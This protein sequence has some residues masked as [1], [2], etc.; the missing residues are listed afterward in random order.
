MRSAWWNSNSS[1]SMSWVS[2]LAMVSF[3]NL[4]DLVVRRLRL[5][6]IIW[7]F[8]KITAFVLMTSTSSSPLL[9]NCVS[10]SSFFS[11]CCITCSPRTDASRF[12]PS[13]L[14]DTSLFTSIAR[15]GFS[16]AAGTALPFIGPRAPSLAVFLRPSRSSDPCASVHFSRR[17]LRS[18]YCSALQ[19]RS[20][21]FFFLPLSWLTESLSPFLPSP[22]AI[23]LLLR[24]PST[25]DGLLLVCGF[26]VS[27]RAR[28]RARWLLLA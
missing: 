5:S 23:G 19:A 15:I 13:L 7:M 9:P 17:W 3:Y 25:R 24:A 27:A 26:L 11:A 16:P 18:G 22:A 14:F 8:C 21:D 4:H 20:A 6:T 10:K 28:P 12:S 2:N 1:L